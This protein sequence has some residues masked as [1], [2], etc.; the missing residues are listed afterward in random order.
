ML[1]ALGVRSVQEGRDGK[2]GKKNQEGDTDG[3]RGREGSRELD[4]MGVDNAVA[5][6][7]HKC[8]A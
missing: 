2:S 4:N 3:V 1:P 8:E 6:E 7:L 5:W